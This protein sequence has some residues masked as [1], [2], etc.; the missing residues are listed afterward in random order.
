M[1][2]RASRAGIALSRLAYDAKFT[3]TR[4]DAGYPGPAVFCSPTTHT[5]SEAHTIKDVIEAFERIID[6]DLTQDE[7]EYLVAYPIASNSD[8]R[9]G[10]QNAKLHSHDHFQAWANGVVYKECNDG[11]SKQDVCLLFV[12]LSPG[13][14]AAMV[15]YGN[16]YSW[17]WTYNSTG[18]K[19]VI[20]SEKEQGDAENWT[21]QDVF[22][23]LVQPI[24]TPSNKKLE[25]AGVLRPEGS[26]PNLS[27]SELETKFNGIPVKWVQLT[28]ISYGAAVFMNR[29]SFGYDSDDVGVGP[30]IAPLPIGIA[31]ANGKTTTIVPA[32][33]HCPVE[34]QMF[35]TNSQDNQT[36]VTV[37]L[38]RGTTPIN[39]LTLKGL[40]PKPRGEARIKVICEIEDHADYARLTIKEV[41]DQGGRDEQQGT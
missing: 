33:T 21:T 11:E 17:G 34:R 2:S 9:K 15:G 31:L 14:V 16:M 40:T 20:L 3:I 36:T 6:F 35:F 41:D 27:A 32:S 12:D 10:V 26:L 7:N 22:D 38:L 18:T 4:V 8:Q 13:Q 29:Q 28:D 1:A 37:K 23:K 39:E 30:A 5:L 25:L 19:S 24:L